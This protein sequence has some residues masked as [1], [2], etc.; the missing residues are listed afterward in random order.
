MSDENMNAYLEDECMPPTCK[1]CEHR[2]D[3]KFRVSPCDMYSLGT[4]QECYDK[5]DADILKEMECSK[6]SK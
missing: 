6:K 4:H 1:G 5:M 2:N 3:K